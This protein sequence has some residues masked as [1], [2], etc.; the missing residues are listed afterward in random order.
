MTYIPTGEGWL[1]LAGCRTFSAAASWAGR[2]AMRS[3][4]SW[5]AA[6]DMA[7]HGRFSAGGQIFHSDRGSQYRGP[8]RPMLVAGVEY[9]SRCY[10]DLLAGHGMKASMSGKGNCWDNA[11]SETLFGS[12]KF[13]RLHGMEFHHHRERRTPRSTGCWYNDRGCTRRCAFSAQHSSSEKQPL[14]HSQ[15]DAKAQPQRRKSKT[16]SL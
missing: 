7:W 14:K 12:L 8:R 2:W 15:P 3:R 6:L 4:R 1:Y 9:A 16:T 5:L 13:E 11:C 10:T